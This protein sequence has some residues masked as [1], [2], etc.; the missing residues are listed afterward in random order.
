MHLLH[1]IVD[2]FFLLSV[3]LAVTPKSCR[4]CDGKYLVIF[5]SYV[6]EAQA[7][8]FIKTSLGGCATG[9]EYLLFNPGSNDCL[10]TTCKDWFFDMKAWRYCG[11]G[12]SVT[13]KKDNHGIGGLMALK[14]YMGLTC[15]RS[16]E[17][18]GNC[19][20]VQCGC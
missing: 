19:N 20:C 9:N 17:C 16:V 15:T 6:S 1:K 11:N 7:R 2:F 5:N 3:C 18:H 8:E 14:D 12:G 10:G 13:L 4:Q